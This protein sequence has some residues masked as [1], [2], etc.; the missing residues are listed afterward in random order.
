MRF[1]SHSTTKPAF[2]PTALPLSG[3]QEDRSGMVRGVVVS[4]ALLL[5]LGAVALG[6]IKP[7]QVDAAEGK[8]QAS[9]EPAP[10]QKL[11]LNVVPVPAPT[12]AAPAEQATEETPYIVE[13]RIRSGDSLAT[14]L[15]RV[16]VSDANLLAFIARESK[17]RSIYR[18][19]VGRSIQAATNDNGELLWVRYYHTPNADANGAGVAKTLQI[20]A[21]KAGFV[22]E[23]LLQPLETHVEV[24]VG[25]I[26]SS[27]FAA[28][29]IAGVPDGITSQM[30]EILSSKID[31]L[32]GLRPNDQFRVVY[33]TRT[34]GGRTAGNGRVLALEFINGKKTHNAVWFSPDGQTGGYYDLEGESLRGAFLR[35]ALKFSRISSTFGMR[36]IPGLQAWS[37]HHPGVDYA[38]P[39]GTPIHATADGTVEFVGWRNGYGNTVILKHHSRITTLY[40]H[41]SRFASGLQ[42]GSKVS[43]GD[44]IGYVGSTGWST[45]PHLHYEFRVADKPIDPLTATANMPT[46]QPLA[47]EHR[48]KF[49]EVVTPFKQQLQ[50]LAKFQEAVPETS[51]VA[52]R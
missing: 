35:S 9:N 37:G 22:A 13:T 44:L 48:E 3:Q 19:N 26:R 28:T 43:Q 10:E 4:A 23:E 33:E 1:K 52:G 14:V 51:N 40:A 50:V 8:P 15:K 49:A 11:V 25:T 29:D 45:G 42:V 27:L 18:L 46:S 20:T 34:I 36:R 16:D 47:P 21:T 7:T 12:E 39:T 30:A 6:V 24:A 5:A 38:A 31:F 2:A 32:R 41:Q 17:A